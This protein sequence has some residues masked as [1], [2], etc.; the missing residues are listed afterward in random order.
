MK[1]V[2]FLTAQLYYRNNIKSRKEQPRREIVKSATESLL[3]IVL[4]LVTTMAF[5]G[6]CGNMISVDSIGVNYVEGHCAPFLK[7]SKPA[8]YIKFSCGAPYKKTCGEA[9]Y[10]KTHGSASYIRRACE[11]PFIKAACEAPYKRTHGLAPM[12]VTVCAPSCEPPQQ[13]KPSCGKE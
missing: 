1:I 3:T 8:P 6:G 7:A 10:M 12:I 2:E 9:P 11:A 13:K 5:C 4:C